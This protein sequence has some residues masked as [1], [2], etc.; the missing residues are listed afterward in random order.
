MKTH[1]LS[2]ST[3]YESGPSLERFIPYL[4]L[5]HNMTC[6]LS[7]GIETAADFPDFD[8][9]DDAD[10]MFVFCKR[11]NLQGEQ[12]AAIK[13]WGADGKPVIGVRTASHAFQ[14]WLEFDKEILGGDYNNHGPDEDPTQVTVKTA[15]PIVAG[16]TDWSRPGRVYHNPNIAAD[17]TELLHITSPSGISEPVAWCRQYND[18]GGRSFYTSMG[19][20]ADFDNDNFRTLIVNAIR[21][22]TAST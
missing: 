5:A 3:E 1:F 9:L 2:G 18:K 10:V 14:T 17:A 13:Q 22:A 6:T 15:H 21:W 12:L 11:M 20:P 16:V 4:E 7:R 8:A 19:L